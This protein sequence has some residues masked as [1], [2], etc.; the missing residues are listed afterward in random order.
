[1]DYLFFTQVG[2]NVAANLLKFV[3][4]SFPLLEKG[5][6]YYSYKVSL[7]CAVVYMCEHVQP[8]SLFCHWINLTQKYVQVIAYSIRHIGY[9]FPVLGNN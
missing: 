8:A 6:S 9:P 2:V 7:Q 3:V 4:N 5:T 1:M